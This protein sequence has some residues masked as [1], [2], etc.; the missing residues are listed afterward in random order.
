MLVSWRVATVAN[1]KLPLGRPKK[2]F[3]RY[4]RIGS[5]IGPRDFSLNKTLQGGPRTDGYKWGVITYNP[6]IWPKINAWVLD[7]LVITLL[8]EVISPHF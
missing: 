6:C 3:D 4:W 5:A 2:P 8:I 7:G 1:N